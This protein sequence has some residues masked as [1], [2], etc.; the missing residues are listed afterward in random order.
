M[1][2]IDLLKNH[3][4]AIKPLAKIYRDILGETW[5]PERPISKTIESLN[6]HLNENQ[7]PLTFVAFDNRTPVGMCSLRVDD[8]LGSKLTPWLGS[9]VVSSE[10]Q[11][12]GIAKKLINI[13]KERAKSLGFKK[14]YLFALDETI[15]QYYQ[16]LGWDIIGN[17]IFQNYP[18]TVMEI[19]LD[20]Q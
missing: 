16:S 8:G 7:L 1:I 12:Q 14:L 19:K 6:N 13:T 9:L 10:Y 5:F 3:P 18:V 15:P 11:K 2:N 4:V 20:L 17:D